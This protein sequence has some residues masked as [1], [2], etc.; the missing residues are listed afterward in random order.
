[1]A[2]PYNVPLVVLAGHH[3]RSSAAVLHVVAAAGCRSGV[4]P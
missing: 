4:V 1:M 2:V 3:K